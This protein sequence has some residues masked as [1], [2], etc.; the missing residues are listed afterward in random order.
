MELKDQDV[1]QRDLHKEKKNE[2]INISTHIFHKQK[3]NPP[4][5]KFFCLGF[6]YFLSGG[7]LYER[8]MHHWS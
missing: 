5:C 7:D 4:A 2:H 3:S 8:V 1:V 6:V